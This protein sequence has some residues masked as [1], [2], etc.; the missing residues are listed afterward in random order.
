MVNQT[1]SN[2]NSSVFNTWLIYVLIV[3]YALCYQL[4]RPLEP[5][6]VDKLVTNGG[7]DEAAVAYSKVT[8]FFSVMQG[9]GSLCMGS[10]LDKF[11]FRAG[12]LVNFLASSASYYFLS[13]SDSLN[14]LYISKLPGMMMGG[15]LCAQTAIATFTANGPNRIKALGLLTTSYT[16]GSVVGLYIGG[17]IGKSG[18]Y[19][20]TAR[21]ATGGSLFACA[22][23]LL[24][25]GTDVS[26]I[27]SQ[28]DTNSENKD[29]AT[30]AEN[31]SSWINRAFYLL[32]I[33]GP[34]L[35]VKI[36][37]GLANNMASSSQFL[38]NDLGFD[39]AAMG[40]VMSAQMAFG[41]FSNA[42]LLGP[43][44][45]L[46]GGE[47]I[48]VVKRCVLIMGCVYGVQS[49]LFQASTPFMVIDK[50]YTGYIY[51]CFVLFLAMFQYSLSTS[52]TAGTQALV[53]KAMIGNLMGIEHSFFAI[54]GFIG[55]L[56]G[57]YIFISY[58]ISGLSLVCSAIYFIIL[59]TWY[60]SK[61]PPCPVAAK[62][63]ND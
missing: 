32:S 55:P 29:T 4:Q 7:A 16:V 40:A 47:I 5:F 31:D 19:Y 42:F 3:L 2:K 20:Y 11:G 30:D 1:T 18:D 43:L 46:L 44:T 58:G 56:I 63:A 26:T 36:A 48:S 59:F 41:G 17:Y 51:F 28:K 54:A 37:S 62:Q 23:V 25:P 9:V 33:A 45:K 52:I 61:S 39:E 13:I 14:M 50:E 57:T 10:I 60:R 38:K 53:P 27:N 6:L 8:S 24:L 15:F 12:F 35:S 49:A 21:M 22:L 34:L